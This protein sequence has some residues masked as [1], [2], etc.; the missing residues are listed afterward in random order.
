MNFKLIYSIIQAQVFQ[1][2]QN[3]N[4]NY[5]NAVLMEK[6]GMINVIVGNVNENNAY[7]LQFSKGTGVLVSCV[8]DF[9]IE[10]DLKIHTVAA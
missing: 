3:K 6:G 5:S 9:V 10:G 2:C 4:I 1:F 7:R 8:K